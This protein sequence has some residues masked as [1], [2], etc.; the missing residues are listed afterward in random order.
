MANIQTW[1]N[2]Q[3]DI[4]NSFDGSA[5][6]VQFSNEHIYVYPFEKDDFE[7]G[8]VFNGSYWSAVTIWED[9]RITHETEYGG[10]GNGWCGG[11]CATCQ[12][13]NWDD[14]EDDE[15]DDNGGLNELCLGCKHA[16]SCYAATVGNCIHKN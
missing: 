4:R 10:C 1:L 11:D 3:S 7:N 2:I 12:N 5:E 13:E 15:D 14:A 8:R 16:G 6:I 9:G